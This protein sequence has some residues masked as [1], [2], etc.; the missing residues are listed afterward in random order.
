MIKF[1]KLTIPKIQEQKREIFPEQKEYLEKIKQ[2]EELLPEEDKL[3]RRWLGVA[4]NVIENNAE[5][6]GAKFATKELEMLDVLLRTRIAREKD[7]KVK[8]KLYQAI[9]LFG[10]LLAG[11]QA[12]APA[13][14]TPSAKAETA[15]IE[16]RPEKEI[17]KILDK[18]VSEWFDED[19]DEKSDELKNLF[20]I[21]GQEETSNMT[22]ED[23]QK[24]TKEAIEQ[25]VS[26]EAKTKIEKVIADWLLMKFIN[27][28]TDYPDDAAT[29]FNLK[30]VLTPTEQGEYFANCIGRSQL[31]QVL[32]KDLRLDIGI[33][34]VIKDINGNTYKI[35][36][37]S[38]GH[39]CNIINFS[40]NTYR[41]DDSTA[42][43]EDLFSIKKYG[44]S[45]IKHQEIIGKINGQDANIDLKNKEY[46]LDKQE[47]WYDLEKQDKIE[48]LSKE[49]VQARVH[50]GQGTL[51]LENDNT[52]E[53]I[54]N[55]EQVVRLD[56]SSFSELARDNLDALR[57][58]LLTTYMNNGLRAFES[59]DYNQAEKMFNKVKEINP[60][61]GDA[62]YNLG[63]TYGTM[64]NNVKTNNERLRLY[65]LTLK[66]LKKSLELGIDSKYESQAKSMI[67]QLESIFK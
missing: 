60:E 43:R 18:V 7:K 57:V 42:Y 41:L 17:K 49:Q 62:Y 54:K 24:Y 29:K 9:A 36:Q 16:S 25:Q 63:I 66:N 32:G 52:E 53:A 5:S 19:F 27:K 61:N 23:L 3:L 48:G 14:L 30:D 50:M 28:H 45:D 35:G 47:Q 56:K 55:F 26:P 22:W 20:Q 46:Q 65:K 4:K 11:Y 37:V 34:D 31:Y 12:L 51:E 67:T 38:I 8:L 64:S 39:N 6:K 21:I 10:L 15:K 44:V 40:D 2:I 1:E 33:I 58:H 59:K 13:E